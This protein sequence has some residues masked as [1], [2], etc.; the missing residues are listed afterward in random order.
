MAGFNLTISLDGQN[1]LKAMEAFLSPVTFARALQGGTKY[2]AKAATP[3]IAKA[4]GAR[5]TWKAGDIKADVKGPRF[6]DGGTTAILNLSRRPRTAAAFGGRQI[7]RG[8]SFAIF[9]GER[10]TFRRGFLA[11]GKQGIQ[12]PFYRVGKDRY[13]IDVIHGPSLGSVFMGDSRFGEVMQKE[14]EAR[15]SEQFIKGIERELARK[16]RGY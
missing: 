3:A 5:Y 6:T 15:M 12:L 4:V 2:A 8:Y 11:Q 7:K 16:Q 14:V 10:Q 9:K 1:Q 13:P